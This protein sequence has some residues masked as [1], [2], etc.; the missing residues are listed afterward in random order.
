MSHLEVI[1]KL[2]STSYI[3]MRVVF[4]PAVASEEVTQFNMREEIA[5]FAMLLMYY[6]NYY[7]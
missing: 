1:L 4:L 7:E 6:V 3:K 2:F 5:V